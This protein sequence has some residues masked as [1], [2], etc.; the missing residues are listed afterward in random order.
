MLTSLPLVKIALAVYLTAQGLLAN[1][2]YCHYN[3]FFSACPAF[4]VANFDTACGGAEK[5]RTS[6]ARPYGNA[7]KGR[8]EVDNPDGVIAQNYPQ[9]MIEHS[10]AS[11]PHRRWS[12]R[13]PSSVTRGDSSF[14]RK[15]P[16]GLRGKRQRILFM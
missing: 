10:E 4:S 5:E 12:L 9:A 6:T 13:E 8:G 16:R 15:E 11:K 3:T 7:A 14:P 2:W 1:L